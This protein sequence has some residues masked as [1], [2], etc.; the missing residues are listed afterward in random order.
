MPSPRT[1]ARHSPACRRTHDRA[2]PRALRRRGSARAIPTRRRRR[3]IVGYPEALEACCRATGPT[4]SACVSIC[5]QTRSPSRRVTMARLGSSSSSPTVTTSPGCGSNVRSSARG[6]WEIQHSTMRSASTPFGS[7][8]RSYDGPAVIAFSV[9]RGGG[10]PRRDCRSVRESVAVPERTAQ[11]SVPT[12]RSSSAGGRGSGAWGTRRQGDHRRSLRGAA[13]ESPR[14][15]GDEPVGHSRRRALRGQRS[16]RSPTGHVSRPW[17]ARGARR[18]ACSH[19]DERR[20]R[21]RPLPHPAGRAARSRRRSVS[22]RWERAAG[23]G[24]GARRRPCRAPAGN[25]R[26]EPATPGWRGRPVP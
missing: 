4:A 20:L 2:V 1:A 26:S 10:R 22:S 24:P 25:G 9:P 12:V 23:C 5:T 17:C 11:L 8:Q 19:P 13:G 6:P 14:T 16:P 7:N 15:G 18:R 21:H 3:W